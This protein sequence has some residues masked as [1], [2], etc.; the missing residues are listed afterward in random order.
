MTQWFT[1]P[2]DLV[3]ASC[4]CHLERAAVPSLFCVD[5]GVLAEWSSMVRSTDAAFSAV[6]KYFVPGALTLAPL[7]QQQLDDLAMLG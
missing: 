6:P 2:D 5:V 4:R 3:M 7:P 1:G